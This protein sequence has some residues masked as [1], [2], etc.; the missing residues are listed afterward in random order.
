MTPGDGAGGVGAASVIVSVVL[1]LLRQN[2]LA[3]TLAAVCRMIAFYDGRPGFACAWFYRKTMWAKP[4]DIVMQGVLPVL[5][6]G[7][8][9]GAFIVACKLYAAPDYGATSI[10]GIGGV[11]LIGVGSLLLGVV[12]M[13]AYQAIAPEYFRGDTLPKRES[14]DLVLVGG[15]GRPTGMRLPDSQERTVIAPDLSNLPPGQTAADPRHGERFE[16]PDDTDDLPAG[17]L[18]AD[19]VEDA[20]RAV[21]FHDVANGDHRCPPGAWVPVRFSSHRASSAMG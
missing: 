4:R 6:G 14:S 8:L 5:G 13:F 18:D 10:G 9:L 21:I 12:L 20:V 19:A 7:L 15:G 2:S 11:F 1:T 16:R 17:E 3:G